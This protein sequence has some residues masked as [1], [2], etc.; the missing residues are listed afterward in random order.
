MSREC[1]SVGDS[2][3]EGDDECVLSCV[4]VDDR[5]GRTEGLCVWSETV[6]PG[7][8]DADNDSEFDIVKV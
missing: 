3:G 4:G 1:V 2:V 6:R 5:E 8:L 7:V